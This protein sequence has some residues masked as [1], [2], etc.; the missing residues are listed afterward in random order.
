MEPCIVLDRH[1]CSQGLPRGASSMYKP[2]WL[3]EDESQCMHA[4]SYL[5]RF[6]KPVSHTNSCSLASAWPTTS[7]GYSL[8]LY[9]SPLSC[10]SNAPSL[11]V[12]ASVSPSS[13]LF[14][15]MCSQLLG[16]LCAGLGGPL[17]NV[18]GGGGQA[19]LKGDVQLFPHTAS[20]PH[21]SVAHLAIWG[22]IGPKQRMQR[23][24]Y[25]CTVDTHAHAANWCYPQSILSEY[26]DL[27][28]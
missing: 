23:W 19:S 15:A 10:Q 12:H 27:S 21:W 1:M 18:V 13:A 7:A 28:N 8:L 11:L 6:P 17:W 26:E 20:T 24:N 5:P 16:S 4:S 9:S 3:S 2:V 22:V 14:V 25:G